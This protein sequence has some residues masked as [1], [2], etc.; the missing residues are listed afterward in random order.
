VGQYRT[1]Q[2]YG[3]LYPQGSPDKDVLDRIIRQLIDDGTLAKL[4]AVHLGSAFG[5]DPATI[6]YF[7][8]KDAS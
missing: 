4:S 1:D 3:A 8:V 2:G 7:T 5:Q 6:P